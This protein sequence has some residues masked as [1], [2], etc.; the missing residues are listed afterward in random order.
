VAVIGFGSQGRAIA[1]NLRDSG[2]AVAV[3]LRPRSKSRGQAKKERG[4]KVLA[5]PEAV[6]QSEVICFAF[7]DHLHRKVFEKDIGPHLKR[8]TALWF[9]HGSS[10]HF[11]LVCPAREVAVLMVAPHA[12]GQAV[13]EQYLGARGLSAFYAVHTGSRVTTVLARQL[14][15]AIG[16]K[17]RNLLKTTFEQEAVGDLFGEQAVLC[18]GLAALIQAGFQTLVNNGWS[19]DNA[20]LEV[21]HQLDLIV[22]LIKKHGITGM[23]SRISPAA[24]LGS[25]G[26]GGKIIDRGTR[27]RLQRLFEEIASGHFAA[28]LKRLDDTRLRQL[29][30]ELIRLSDPR[31]EKAARRFRTKKS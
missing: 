14:A 5:I 18:G 31:L 20:Y 3:G 17:P 23:L 7:P 16:I 2:F 9:L 27:Q 22:A 25:L 21:A 10:I 13:R 6:A 1:L 15:W 4:L 11:G 12:P 19:A 26:S 28:R 8:G 24:R 29:D 30:R